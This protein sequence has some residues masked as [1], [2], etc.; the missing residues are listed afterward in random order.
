MKVTACFIGNDTRYVHVIVKSSDWG[1]SKIYSFGGGAAQ[2]TREVWG[3]L[4]GNFYCNLHIK[5]L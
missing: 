5:H 3:M 1:G 2:H 4:P